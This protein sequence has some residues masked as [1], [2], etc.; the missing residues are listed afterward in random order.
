MF[1]AVLMSGAIGATGSAVSHFGVG[2]G[3]LATTVTGGVLFAI[4]LAFLRLVALSPAEVLY[5]KALDDK[6]LDDKLKREILK[7]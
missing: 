2:A 4:F 1:C 6:S 3:L 7:R 5:S